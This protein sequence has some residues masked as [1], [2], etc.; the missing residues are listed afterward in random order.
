[1]GVVGR[2]TSGEHLEKRPRGAKVFLKLCFFPTYFKSR[3]HIIFMMIQW[4]RFA[5]FF[6][7]TLSN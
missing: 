3:A 6:L 5:A 4:I 1:M 7:V 2:A